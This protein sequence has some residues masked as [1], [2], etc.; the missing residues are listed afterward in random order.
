MV[1]I[2]RHRPSGRTPVGRI[3]ARIPPMLPVPAPQ[4]HSQ[5]LPICCAIFHASAHSLIF[6]LHV[7][8]PVHLAKIPF[9]LL[10]SLLGSQT[11]PHPPTRLFLPPASL[12]APAAPWCHCFLSAFLR[13]PSLPSRSAVELF[14]VQIAGWEVLTRQVCR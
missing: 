2:G 9:G 10:G 3:W 1:R 12:I 7:R 4:K 6:S 11:L 5:F 14:K 13:E 8:L